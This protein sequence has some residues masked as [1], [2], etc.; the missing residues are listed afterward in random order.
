[1]KRIVKPP[2]ERR[3]EL[4]HVGIQLFIERGIDSV[5]IKHI[6]SHANVATGLFYYYFPS[7]EVFIE[8]AIQHFMLNYVEHLIDTLRSEELPLTKRILKALFDFE[9]HLQKATS[10]WTNSTLTLSQHHVFEHIMILQITPVLESVIKQGITEGVFKPIDPTIATTFLLHG[11]SGIL[12]MK[13]NG[14]CIPDYNATIEQ[15]V[16]SALGTNITE[17]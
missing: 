5:A 11:L 7:K 4:L 6:V 12:H 10:L 16:L 1:M 13:L 15:I 2:D 9:I 3:I 8:E 14:K 17:R